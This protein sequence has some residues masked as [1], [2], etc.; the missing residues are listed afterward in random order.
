MDLEDTEEISLA[1]APKPDVSHKLYQ[2][3]IN[4]HFH[5]TVVSSEPP[6]RPRD[7]RPQESRSANSTA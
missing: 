1:G 5:Q 7:S 6:H 2:S 4:E 3:P